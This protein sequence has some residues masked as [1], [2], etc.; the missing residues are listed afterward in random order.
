MVFLL[1]ADICVLF[2]LVSCCGC[3]R[4]SHGTGRKYNYI[5]WC[6]VGQCDILT[7]K[8]AL[9]KTVYYVTERAI[10]SLVIV[11]A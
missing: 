4:L 9:V 2:L 1:D 7:V 10:F 11:R 5:Y 3:N 6:A 8:N